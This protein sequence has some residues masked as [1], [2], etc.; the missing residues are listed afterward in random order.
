MVV[1]A[2]WLA[3][4]V[5]VVAVAVAVQPAAPPRCTVLRVVFVVVA[6]CWAHTVQM[7][8]APV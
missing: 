6:G 2:A 1:V 5:A 7:V 4:T 8:A 3:G